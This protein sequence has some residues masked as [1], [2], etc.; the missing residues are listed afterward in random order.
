M[1]FG[2]D[3]SAFVIGHRGAAGTA[4]ENTLAGIRDAAKQGAKWVEFDVKLTRDGVPVLFHDETLRRTLEADGRVAETLLADLQALDA[5]VGERVPTL[6]EAL[7]LLAE[8]GL[9]AN[10]ELKPCPGREAETG[11]VVAAALKEAR[12]PLLVSSFSEAALAA[13]SAL[14]RALLVGA[15]P[16]D[17]RRRLA[18]VGAADLHCRARGLRRIQVV[19]VTRRG[20]RLRCYTVNDAAA[21]L[22]LRRWGVA[23]VFSDFPGRLL[24]A[25]GPS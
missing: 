21:A 2:P 12:T 25:L 16:R 23:G 20:I 9:G 7:A 15:I 19:E 6:A 1:E 5:G 18:R 3:D 13:A 24:A 22:R 10:V 8:L 14:P 11:R 17:W 4:P